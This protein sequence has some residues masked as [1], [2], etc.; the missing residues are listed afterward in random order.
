MN[1]NFL[2]TL[3]RAMVQKYSGRYGSAKS[4]VWA[5]QGTL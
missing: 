2:G 5:R 4:Q 3:R 1:S